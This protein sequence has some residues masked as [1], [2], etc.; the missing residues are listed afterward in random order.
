[1][2][3]M[4]YIKQIPEEFDRD[5]SQVGDVELKEVN[6]MSD[7]LDFLR[8][9]RFWALVI[10]A[11]MFYLQTKGIIGDAEMILA[12]TILGGFITIKTI[13]RASEQKVLAAEA[14]GKVTT[15]AMPEGVSSVTA[16]TEDK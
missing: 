15:V 3:V 5:T 2:P 8:S 16:K 9:T 6:N 12:N 4:R 14:S 10:G 7:K 1:M 11:I 13:D